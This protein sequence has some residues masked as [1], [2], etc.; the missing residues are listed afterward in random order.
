M[1]PSRD[2]RIHVCFREEKDVKFLMPLCFFVRNCYQADL[3]PILVALNQLLVR[4]RQRGQITGRPAA[5][6]FDRRRQLSQA[7]RPAA[8][9][10][11]KHL[12]VRLGNYRNQSSI[13]TGRLSGHAIT[14]V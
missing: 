13:C 7:L 11:P 9:A 1:R 4:R 3:W 5:N 6:Q 12:K 2:S 8:C 14:P 10:E